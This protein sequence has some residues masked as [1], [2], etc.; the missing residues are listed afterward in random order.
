MIIT[1]KQL[2]LMSSQVVREWNNKWL[3]QEGS[4]MV[5]KLY[6]ISYPANVS[7][8]QENHQSVTPVSLVECSA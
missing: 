2:T 3:S 4:A 5:E 8:A 1:L 6:E 7:N